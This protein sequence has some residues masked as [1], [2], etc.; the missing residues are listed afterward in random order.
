MQNPNIPWVNQINVK[1]YFI[2]FGVEKAGYKSKYFCGYFK[3]TSNKKITFTTNKLI[4]RLSQI[5]AFLF[6]NFFLRG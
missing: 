6:Q 2:K 5:E 4:C 3:V 1:F